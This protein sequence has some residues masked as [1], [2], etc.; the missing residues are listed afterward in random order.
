MNPSDCG[1]PA[2]THSDV[3]NSVAE[4]LA[5]YLL[6]AGHGVGPGTDG[7]T[8]ADAVGALYH[9][10]AR[11]GHV[12]GLAEL[13]RRHPELAESIAAFVGQMGYAEIH[14]R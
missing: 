3:E 7:L 4:L 6:S 9:A 10:E 13:V 8:V 2:G 14:G 12:P 5:G 11:A 1:A